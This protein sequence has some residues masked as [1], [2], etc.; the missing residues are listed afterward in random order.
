MLF[1]VI[2]SLVIVIG[3]IYLVLKLLQRYVYFGG[4]KALNMINLDTMSIAATTYIDQNNKVIKL[5]HLNSYYL[6][7]V[8]KTNNLLL[9]KHEEVNKNGDFN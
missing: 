4:N 7:L 5:K 8:S 3:L 9:D 1:T 6:I 2:S